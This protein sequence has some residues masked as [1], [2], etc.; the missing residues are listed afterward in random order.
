ME[1]LPS[2]M[3][4]CYDEDMDYMSKLNH[5]M[6]NDPC[7]RNLVTIH[8]TLTGSPN[9]FVHSISYQSSYYSN[10]RPLKPVTPIPKWYA[11]STMSIVICCVAIWNTSINAQN[12]QIKSISL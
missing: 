10:H 1:Q 4:L 7:I 3:K 2:H 9:R 11:T 8:E 6:E 12:V 5:E